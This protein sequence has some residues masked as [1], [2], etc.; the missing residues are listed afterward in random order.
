[1]SILPAPWGPL[2]GNLSQI[3]S[4]ELLSRAGFLLWKKA[5]LGNSGF[6]CQLPQEDKGASETNIVAKDLVVG[7]RAMTSKWTECTERALDKETS[8]GPLYPKKKKSWKCCTSKRSMKW[9]NTWPT[10][11][12]FWCHQGMES[13]YI[14]ASED[15]IGSFLAQK[16]EEGQALSYRYVGRLIRAREKWHSNW[17]VKYRHDFTAVKLRHYLWPRQTSCEGYRSN[18]VSGCMYRYR[19]GKWGFFFDL[20]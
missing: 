15:S 13:L 9:R 1:M 4:R 6:S 14:S 19:I 11:R 20:S 10:G 8:D 3:L 17:F 18:S 2:S 12:Q 7:V 5:I 16:N